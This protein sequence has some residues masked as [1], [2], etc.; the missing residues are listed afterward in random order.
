MATAVS[1]AK[2]KELEQIKALCKSSED[3]VQYLKD[4]D[5]HFSKINKVAEY[6][7][8]AVKQWQKV[9]PL[10]SSDDIQVEYRPNT[11][12]KK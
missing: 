5:E 4:A 7:L 8:N 9:F 12:I 1:F 11:E 6:N 3:L 10:V 2:R